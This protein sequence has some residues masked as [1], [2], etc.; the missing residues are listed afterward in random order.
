MPCDE[1]VYS[2]AMRCEKCTVDSTSPLAVSAACAPPRGRAQARVVIRT[3]FLGLISVELQ[4]QIELEHEVTLQVATMMAAGV[5]KREVI[6]SLNIA[7]VIYDMCAYRL[8]G[9]AKGMRDEKV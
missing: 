4:K 7:E 8:R 9:I 5:G 3:G 1:C 6:E 2:T